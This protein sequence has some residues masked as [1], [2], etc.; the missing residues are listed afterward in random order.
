MATRAAPEW[1]LVSW[2]PLLMVACATAPPQP[3]APA[4]EAVEFIVLQNDSIIASEEQR[5]YADRIAGSVAVLGLARMDYVA[6]TGRDDRIYRLEAHIMPWRGQPRGDS[7]AVQ[8][9]GDSVYV[10]RIRPIRYTD[11][12][13]GGTAIPY[14]YPS[15]GLLEQVAVAAMHSAANVQLQGGNPQFRSG[16][17]PMEVRVWLVALNTSTTAQVYVYP[18]NVYDIELAQR[19][20]RVWLENG[21]MVRAEVPALGWLIQRRAIAPAS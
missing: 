12:H 19:R 7:V 2:L 18:D 20:I 16:S 17:A 21:R 8:F 13:G 15:P 14:L 1:G 6:Y 5:I 11:V 9:R 10:E 3:S 4:L